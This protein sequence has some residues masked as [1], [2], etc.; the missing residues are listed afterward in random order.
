MNIIYEP[1]NKCK[2]TGGKYI[3][4][5]DDNGEEYIEK[6]KC[7]S[8]YLHK[9]ELYLKLLNAGIKADYI[10]DYTLSDYIGNDEPL[11]ISSSDHIIDYDLNVILEKFNDRSIEVGVVCFDSIHPKWSFVRLDDNGKIIETA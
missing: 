9:K 5:T 1:C 10:L 2:L 3:H 6:C 4:F 11:L 7:Y 8:D